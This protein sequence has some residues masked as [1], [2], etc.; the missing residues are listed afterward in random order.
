MFASTTNH[1]KFSSRGDGGTSK[2]DLIFKGGLLNN[3]LNTTPYP[4]HKGVL[5]IQF[6]GISHVKVGFILL[7]K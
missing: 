7:Q 2:I 1:N 3:K 5:Q 4:C 6:V